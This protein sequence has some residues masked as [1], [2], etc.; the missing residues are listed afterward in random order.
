MKFFFGFDAGGS[1][2]QGLTGLGSS[3]GFGYRQFFELGRGSIGA[4]FL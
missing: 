2:L 1:L 4:S 3:L